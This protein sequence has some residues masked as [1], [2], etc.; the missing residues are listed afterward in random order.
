MKSIM[1]IIKIFG[2]YRYTL[3]DLKRHNPNLFHGDG[4]VLQVSLLDHRINS[5]GFSNYDYLSR[6]S[7]IL[8]GAS[9]QLMVVYEE[10][11]PILYEFS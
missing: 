2:A 11:I 3:V 4:L 7:I 1:N 10:H 9:S 6:N 5:E 8:S